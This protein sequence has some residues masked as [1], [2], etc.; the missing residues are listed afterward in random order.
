[1]HV[2]RQA[3][4]RGEHR[5]AA[6]RVSDDFERVVVARA[7]ELLAA[8]GPA[9]LS[10]RALADA[11]GGSTKL[12]YSHFGGMSGV[13]SLV[14]S[15]AM[16]VLGDRLQQTDAPALSR[17]DRLARMATTYRQFAQDSPHLFRMLY[18][19]PTDQAAQLDW[20]PAAIGMA[21]GIIAPPHAPASVFDATLP[22]ARVF[23]AMIH[24]PVRLESL[25]A[26]GTAADDVFAAVL[27]HATR[28][29]I[30]LPA[31]PGR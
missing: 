23:W 15:E 13:R 19:A 2:S 9:A 14:R 17:V 31:R 18:S 20:D 22:A 30:A 25:G 11:I 16:R 26:L 24:G 5:A 29:A 7:T 10:A 3:F 8:G 21:Q 4:E 27:A 1:V 6:R 12:I 28:A